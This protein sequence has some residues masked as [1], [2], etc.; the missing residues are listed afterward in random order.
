[1]HLAETFDGL[2]LSGL[3][4]Y[5]AYRATMLIGVALLNLYRVLGTI[6]LYGEK[7]LSGQSSPTGERVPSGVFRVLALSGWM[8]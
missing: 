2:G 3:D 8:P 5:R 6:G 1:M 4:A 7:L